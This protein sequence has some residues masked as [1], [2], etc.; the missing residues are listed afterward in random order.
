[1][2]RRI[3]LGYQLIIGL[4]DA[5]TGALLMVVPALTLRMIRL[6]APVDALPYLSFIGAFVFS[7]GVACLYGAFLIVSRCNKAK[8]E[9]VWLLT[10]LTRASV[11]IFITGQV[12][13]GTL[14]AGWLTVAVADGLCAVIQIIGLRQRWLIHV[15][16]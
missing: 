3:L 10:A 15:T 5:L 11:A 4:S 6:Q 16:R 12:L 13:A 8:L 9:V 7:V 2:N 14:E 1:M